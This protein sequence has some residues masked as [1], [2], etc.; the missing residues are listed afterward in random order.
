MIWDCDDLGLVTK[1]T[2]EAWATFSPDGAYRYALARIWAAHGTMLAVCGL[3]PS[4]ADEKVTDLPDDERYDGEDRVS[5]P[6]HPDYW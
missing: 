3:N 6:A 5:V 1:G 4:R 2:P